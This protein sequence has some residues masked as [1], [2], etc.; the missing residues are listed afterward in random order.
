MFNERY[1]GDAVR[2]VKTN[3]FMNLVQGSK[4]VAEYVDKFDELAKFTFDLVPTDVAR[5]DRFVRGLNPGVAHR[6]RVA[7]VHEVSTYALMVGKALAMEDARG[8]I[9]SE[10]VVV[11]EAQARVSP[12]VRAGRGGGPSS[13]K[14]KTSDNSTTVGHDV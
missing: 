7:S 11:Q 9:W 14:R 2:I 1:Y 4:T 6:V 10:G 3:E 13:Q 8:V 12:L 5:K